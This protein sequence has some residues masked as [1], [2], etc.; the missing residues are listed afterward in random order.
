[1]KRFRIKYQIGAQDCSEVIE[2][3]DLAEAWKFAWKRAG[4]LQNDTQ[5]NVTL[6]TVNEC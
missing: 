1:M 5:A 4:E 3:N 2:S 6:K